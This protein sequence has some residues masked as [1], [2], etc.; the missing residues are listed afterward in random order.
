MKTIG[1]IGG[2]SWESTAEYYR[3]INQETNARLGNRHSAKIV[4]VSLDFEEVEELQSS[5]RWDE[6]ASLMVQAAGQVRAGG[7]ELL[8]ICANTMHKLA[9]QVQAAMDIPLIHIVQATARAVRGQGLTKIGLLG[10]RYTMTE[11]FIRGGLEERGLT[12]LVPGAEEMEVVNRIIYDELVLGRILEPSRD[13]LHQAVDRL[14]QAGAQGVILG[15]TELPLLAKEDRSPV[16][17]F[18]TTYLHATA[19]VEA[20]LAS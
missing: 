13:K 15:C 12:V 2:I 6:A 14:A 5:G 7:A 17:L 8:L 19:A 1:L 16:P 11:D 3:I 20:A 10:T 18:D 9:G 4:L